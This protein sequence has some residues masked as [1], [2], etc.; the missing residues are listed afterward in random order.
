MNE[1]S[2]IT[3]VSETIIFHYDHIETRFIHLN[4][5]NV[6]FCERVMH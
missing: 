1:I 5:T 6:S 3:D 2:T 4:I